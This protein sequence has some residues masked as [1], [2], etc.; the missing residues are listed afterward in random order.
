MTFFA[1]GHIAGRRPALPIKLSTDI[2]VGPIGE[3][4]GERALGTEV[5]LTP[6][7]FASRLK[8]DGR[9][10]FLDR[11]GRI[12]VSGHAFLGEDRVDL[13]PN[14]GVELPPH[15]GDVFL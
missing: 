2:L 12:N 1:S 4:A 10:C 9:V 14:L 15:G 13:F 11:L 6:A 3:P 5:S 7:P 8:Q